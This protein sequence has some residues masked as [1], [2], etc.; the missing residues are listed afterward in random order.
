[1]ISEKTGIYNANRFSGDQ[2]TVG[3][4]YDKEI[5]EKYQ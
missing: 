4:T 3:R 5:V 2:S 1:M